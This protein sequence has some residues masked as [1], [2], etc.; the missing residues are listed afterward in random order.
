MTDIR[1][2]MTDA[3]LLGKT[4]GDE[5]WAAWR[6]LLA[7]F[8][9][10]PLSD[11]EANIFHELT[12][13][14]S[15]QTALDELWLV[16]GRRGGKSIISALLAVIV[17][18][19]FEARGRLS[20]GEVAT[21]MVI[22]GDRKQARTVYRYITGLLHSCSM[23][24]GMI[25]KER[26]DG[27]ELTNRVIIE[28]HSSNFRAVRGYTLLAAILDELAFWYSDGANPDAEIVSALRPGLGT[29]GGRLIGL[30]SPYARRG[31]LWETYREQ[32]GKDGP[33]LVAKAPTRTMNPTFP[34]DIIDKAL[35]NDEP[36]ARAEYLA[37]F[38]TD[39]ETF[40]PR[41]VVEA[42]VELG[43]RELAPVSKHRYFAFVDPS[44]GSADSMTLAIAHLEDGV[45]VLDAVRE[46]RPP[47]SPEA[48]VKEFSELLRSYRLVSVMGDRYAGEWP[49][50]RFREHGIHYRV[51]DKTKSGY[52][53]ALLPI[54]N[55][56]KAQL[57]D[58]DRLTHQLISLERRVSRGG[59]DSI[60]HPPK[61]HD[62]VANAVAGALVGITAWH[63]PSWGVVGYLDGP[64]LL[65]PAEGI[66][67]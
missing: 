18:V 43:C 35:A 50:E 3:A 30:S 46:R 45:G 38:R 21:V 53:S 28:V 40:V 5:S 2:W 7:G 57:L 24:K 41:E 8:F 54:L 51:A 44:G 33:I 13:R 61:G 42:C 55:S 4:F 15:L 29:L 23:L 1:K 47:F 64:K 6:A 11:S 39:V 31:V 9:G 36:R 62:D 63:R 48:V 12:G 26:A 32:Y 27:I 65:P 58:N 60:D 25:K 17:A 19:T 52:Y 66:S 14:I 22:A 59:K 37:E 56:G 10:L 49:R 20:A 16:I 67:S 34:Q